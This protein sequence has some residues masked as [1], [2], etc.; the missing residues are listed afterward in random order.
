[1]TDLDFGE[2]YV[3]KG[4][5]LMVAL[6]LLRI[7]PLLDNIEYVDGSWE[8][9]ADAIN[10]SKELADCSSEKHPFVALGSNINDTPP[11]TRI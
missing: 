8:K 4:S 6:T 7:F 5:A 9:V 3:P 10:S 2:I 1:M 11:R